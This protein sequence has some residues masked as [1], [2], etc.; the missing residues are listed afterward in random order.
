M[1]L[2]DHSLV[3][4]SVIEVADETGEVLVRA[5]FVG[6]LSGT[7]TG[8]GRRLRHHTFLAYRPER[9]RRERRVRVYRGA[10]DDVQIG[11]MA[12]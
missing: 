4:Q 1:R 10:I 3:Q 11:G 8:S 9:P 5:D 6:A 2:Q 7:R 12:H